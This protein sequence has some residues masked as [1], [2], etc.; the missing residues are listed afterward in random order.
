MRGAGAPP[1]ARGHPRTN[2]AGDGRAGGGAT[3]DPRD[4]PSR[5][6]PDGAPAAPT[7]WPHRG[8]P[9]PEQRR[10]LGGAGLETWR[11]RIDRR[12]QTRYSLVPYVTAALWLARVEEDAMGLVRKLTLARRLHEERH[13]PT[14]FEFAL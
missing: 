13:R 5:D 9:F 2:G 1:G 3:R 14:G 6:A 11:D 12:T 10:R 4:A 8:T 7:C